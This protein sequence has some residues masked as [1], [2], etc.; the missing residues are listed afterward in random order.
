MSR[1]PPISPL[2]PYPPLFH[3]L[4]P[5]LRLSYPPPKEGKDE[6]HRQEPARATD[7]E[8]GYD[9]VTTPPPPVARAEE[10]TSELQ[11]RQYLVCRLLL[12]K[13]KKKPQNQATNILIC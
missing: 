11:P 13:K 1:P 7:M 6:R 10:H 5:L 8:W 2:F 4:P 3:S 9:H 12:A